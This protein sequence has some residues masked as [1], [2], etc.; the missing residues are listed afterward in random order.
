M[1]KVDS[2]L[3]MNCI[4]VFN[5]TKDKVL[6]CRRRKD[7]FAG[8]LNFVGGKV[9]EGE[10]S[11]DAAYREL[12]EETGISQKEIRLFRLMDITYYHQAFILEMFVGKLE[13]DIEL[14]EEKNPLLWLPLTEDFT[15]RERFAGEQNIAHIINIAMLFPV[16]ERISA[17]ESFPVP[18]RP[19]VPESFS[20]QERDAASK[21]IVNKIKCIRSGGQTGA[22]RAAP[23]LAGKYGIRI[24][25]WCPLGGWAEDFPSPPGLLEKYPELR[26]TPSSETSQRTKW[27]IRD[28]DAILTIMPKGSGES[29]GTEVGIQEGI[30][31]KKPMFTAQGSEDVPEIVAWLNTLPDNLDLCVGG[32]RASE[33]PEVYQITTEILS[34]VLDS[35]QHR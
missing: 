14:R 11:E 34:R 26:E 31:L 13:S 30:L 29:I 21:S 27:N 1:K 7:P 10:A 12:E 5:K 8:R 3:H 9:E 20:A 28:T 24:C 2:F 32:P 6:F 15:N 19:P 16:P 22:D 4:V 25:G 23:D 17:P 35:L 18:E 33:C